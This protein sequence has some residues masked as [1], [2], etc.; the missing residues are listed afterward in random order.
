LADKP[1]SIDMTDAKE[2]GPLDPGWYILS[3]A[4]FAYGTGPSGDRKVDCE[5]SVVKPEGINQKIFDS[6]N[7]VN[8]NTKSRIINVL[9]G[10]GE[11]GTKE[12][13]KANKKFQMPS[14]DEVIG[15]QFAARI[16]TQEDKTGQYSDKS[17]VQSCMTVAAYEEKQASAAAV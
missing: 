2:I 15:M 6:I 10:T 3:I 8:P 17:V 1:I 16:K 5:F 12:E 14:G 9:A 4:K 11:F 13:I 7:L